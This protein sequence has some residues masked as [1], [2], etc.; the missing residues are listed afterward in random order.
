MRSRNQPC[1]DAS[2]SDLPP[3]I[4][5][6]GTSAVI[7]R[8]DR[9]ALRDEARTLSHAH[10]ATE[11]EYGPGMILSCSSGAMR[12]DDDPALAGPLLDDEGADCVT[13]TTLLPWT[14]KRARDRCHLVT[15][16]SRETRS[17]DCRLTQTRVISQH[18][19]EPSAGSAH[20]VVAGPHAG[21]RHGRGLPAA[22]ESVSARAEAPRAGPLRCLELAA[23]DLGTAAL[24]LVDAGALDMLGGFAFTR[25][26]TSLRIAIRDV[27]FFAVRFLSTVEDVGECRK[28]ARSRRVR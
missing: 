4:S 28:I 27:E 19:T 5:C 20:H 12:A 9:R 24:A 8:S 7:R 25:H 11:R 26:G 10:I 14:K 23:A 18:G 15:D 1:L 13:V 3:R 6:C 21:F 17:I 16:L 22:G 2:T